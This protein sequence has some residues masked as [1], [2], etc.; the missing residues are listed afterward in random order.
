MYLHPSSFARSC[1]SFLEVEPPMTI[2]GEGDQLVPLLIY[3]SGTSFANIV[4]K[5]FLGS[6]EH[7]WLQ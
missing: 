2:M 7:E 3:A 4:G 6:I 5:V 1:A